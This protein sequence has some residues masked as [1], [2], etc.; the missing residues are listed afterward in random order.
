MEVDGNGASKFAM[1]YASIIYSFCIISI[2][3]IKGLFMICD[4]SRPFITYQIPNDIVTT[5]GRNIYL[6]YHRYN[7]P[8]ASSSQGIR[9]N[10]LTY[11]QYLFHF[12]T[13]Y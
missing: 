9:L 1:I 2:T 12:P 11:L 13:G 5:S 3:N 8:T 10:H 6:Y 4:T 7:T